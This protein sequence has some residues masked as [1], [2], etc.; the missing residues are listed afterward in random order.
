MR[1]FILE[2]DT[3]AE[4]SPPL[5]PVLEESRP[6]PPVLEE[7]W[8]LSHVLEKSSPLEALEAM[9]NGEAFIPFSIDSGPLGWV[10]YLLKTTISQA[11]LREQML[12]FTYEGNYVQVRRKLEEA[13]FWTLK[14]R[15][16]EL[17]AF[18]RLKQLIACG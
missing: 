1:R 12:P 6:L 15:S 14:E 3:V 4:E 9:L 16:L 17:G 2:D 10:T 5:S 18:E 7:W 11:A 13:E 8:P